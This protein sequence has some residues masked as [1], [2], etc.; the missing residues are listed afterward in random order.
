MNSWRTVTPNADA[1]LKAAE[2]A[3]ERVLLALDFDGTLAPIVDDPLDSRFHEGAAQALGRL[4]TRLGGIAIITG[5]GVGVVRDLGR[6]GEREGLERLV[7]LGQYGVERWDAATGEETSP[8]IPQGV[9]DARVDVERAIAECG[10]AGVALEDKGR[11]LGVHTR[12]S[13]DP[14][15][16]FAAL[17]PVL[18]SIAAAHGLVLEPGR[19]V[20][21]LRASAIT[22]GD[23]LR[24]LV[25]ETGATAVA[26]CG[27]DLGDLPA[28]EALAELRRAGLVTCAVVS[29]SDEQPQV[30][31]HAD[32][33]A[34]GPD[35]VA[36]WL[37]ALG[38]ALS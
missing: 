33:L 26:F 2:A 37:E 30:A 12:R 24:G 34:D 8:D 20:L 1:F 22:K 27:D 36:H 19:N 10:V 14:E 17:A 11:A 29:G 23:A 16:A 15:G 38:G 31:A 21:E 4:G 28:F 18:A 25:K 9:I 7:V 5:R 32:V 3:P 13:A 35:G 6:L